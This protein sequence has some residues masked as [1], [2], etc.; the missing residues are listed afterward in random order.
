M[1]SKTVSK[2]DCLVRVCKYLDV[3]DMVNLSE[4]SKH[5]ELFM[6]FLKERV[7]DL[8]SFDL[9][10]KDRKEVEPLKKVFE[11]F[12]PHMQRVKVIASILFDFT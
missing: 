2:Q 8:N 7:I 4:S 10:P 1:E 9:K 11:H 5:P 3:H 6:E 12:G